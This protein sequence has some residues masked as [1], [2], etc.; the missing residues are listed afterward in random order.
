MLITGKVDICEIVNSNFLNLNKLKCVVVC[1]MFYQ[2]LRF[3]F[4]VFFDGGNDQN[5]FEIYVYVLFD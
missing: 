1:R 2:N 3:K 4:F 5:T